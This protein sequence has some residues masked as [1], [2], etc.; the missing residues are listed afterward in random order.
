MSCYYCIRKSKNYRE[1]NYIVICNRC[2]H[3][4]CNKCYHKYDI[5]NKNRCK[6][7]HLPKILVCYNCDDF[8]RDNL[9]NFFHKDCMVFCTQPKCHKYK[10]NRKYNNLLII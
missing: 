6:F 5:G 3:E 4:L 10:F 8:N 1:I 2:Y 9:D 7:I